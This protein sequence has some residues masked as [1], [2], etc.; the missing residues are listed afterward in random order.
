MECSSYRGLKLLQHAKQFGFMRGEGMIDA[1]FVIRH[2][3]EKFRAKS[4]KL[5]PICRCGKSVTETVRS[6]EMGNA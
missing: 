4:E 6:N 5:F 2:M 1:I 3:Q